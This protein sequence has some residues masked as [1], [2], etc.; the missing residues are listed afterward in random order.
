[1]TAARAHTQKQ[2]H[3]FPFTH[4]ELLDIAEGMEP[5]LPTFTNALIKI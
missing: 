1:M 5:L 2:T 4:R 3:I